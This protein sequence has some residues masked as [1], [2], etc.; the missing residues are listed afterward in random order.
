[1]SELAVSGIILEPSGDE[2]LVADE[3]TKEERYSIN[4]RPTPSEQFGSEDTFSDIPNQSLSTE[5]VLNLESEPSR[6]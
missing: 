2:H 5:N 1:M 3:I 4:Q 6:K